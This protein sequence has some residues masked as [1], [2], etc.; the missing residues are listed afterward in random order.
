[1]SQKRLPNE[2]KNLAE[3][4]GLA[5]RYYIKNILSSDQLIPE[6]A[7]TELTKESLVNLLQLNA[8]EVAMQLMVEDFTVF[9]MIGEG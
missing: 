3:R 8:I 6:D 7:K 9:R 4:I 5:S 2:Q 1:M